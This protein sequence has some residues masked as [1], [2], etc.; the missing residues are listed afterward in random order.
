MTEQAT[1]VDSFEYDIAL[2]GIGRVGLPL[3]LLFA[4]KGLRVLGIDRDSAILDAIEV[5]RMPFKEEGFQELLDDGLTITTAREVA[6][7]RLAEKI[8][9]T[10]GTPFSEH[11]E[12]NLGHVND[13][14][15][16]MIPALVPGQTII[17]R[18][19]VAVGTTEFVRHRIELERGWQLGKE[20]LLAF[21][22]ER[23]LEGKALEELSR[24]PQP[25]GT[26]DDASYESTNALFSHL[27][28]KTFHVSFRGAELIKLFCNTG[29]YV[30]FALVN[31]FFMVANEFD[32]DI[33]ELLAVT[34]EDYPRPILFSP[35]FTGGPCLRKDFAMIS[36]LFPQSDLFT[37]AWRINES[38]P[39][40]IYKA[41]IRQTPFQILGDGEQVRTMTHARDIAEAT[42]LALEKGVEREDFNF[43]GASPF[44]MAD[45]ARV[46]WERINPEQ[47]MPE[48]EHLEAPAADVRFRVG[49]SE[50]AKR[51]LGW[52]PKYDMDDILEDTIAYIRQHQNELPKH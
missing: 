19:T 26:E 50:K 39:K 35:G 34:N 32:E 37:S 4:H 27:T 51:M 43:C 18:S 47:D 7:C 17:P 24:L 13:V 36:E 9:I 1:G 16:E 42:V 12:M 23:I 3:A 8:V 28:E 20:F 33:Y 14:L 5:G 22:P 10:V 29:R 41:L 48:F 40:A 2:I 44:K 31:Y 11:I 46:I 38:L 6:Q 49:Y 52:E 15:K 45:L 30:Y 25:I 21:A